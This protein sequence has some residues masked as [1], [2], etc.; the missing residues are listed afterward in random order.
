[1][2]AAGHQ[3]SI[4]GLGVLAANLDRHIQLACDEQ[5]QARLGALKVIVL[6]AM[7]ARCASR[8]LAATRIPIS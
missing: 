8:A 1:M 6:E 4:A 5:Q 3:L 2:L 7:A